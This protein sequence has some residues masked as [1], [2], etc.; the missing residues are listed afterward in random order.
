MTGGGLDT[1]DPA[2]PESPS[3]RYVVEKLQSAGVVD[4]VVHA[5]TTIGQN[6]RR[7][8]DIP[9]A[10]H[11]GD[12]FHYSN[13][14]S[15]LLASVVETVTGLSYETYLRR[16]I[17]RPLGMKD[18]CF[19]PVDHQLPR[20][21]SVYM[22]HD[23]EDGKKGDQLEKPIAARPGA[24]ALYDPRLAFGKRKTFCHAGGG[25]HGTAEDVY[26][27]A[28]MLANGG[29]VPREGP[30]NDGAV[31]AQPA[32]EERVVSRE[33]VHLM[34]TNRIGHLY[35]P[36]SDNKWGYMLTVQETS[37][38]TKVYYGGAGAFGRRGITGCE[39]WVNPKCDTTVVFMTHA[40]W[41]FDVAHIG[42]KIAQIVNRAVL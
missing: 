22:A 31:E 6:V 13:Y 1:C 25:L 9:L 10:S 23:C 32:A 24:P 15:T 17:F 39:F 42:Q 19:Y 27:F 26:R 4:S 2:G 5:E 16:H 37:E 21:A 11:P 12:V 41:S 28:Q 3:R 35:N 20:L 14:G 29:V 18:T 34:T 8:A 36:L 40:W 33:A 7:S 38:P 30:G